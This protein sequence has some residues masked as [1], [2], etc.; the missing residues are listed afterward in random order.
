MSF[1]KPDLG[2][3]FW[4]VGTGDSST[5][6][7]KDK[8]IQIDLHNMSKAVDEDEPY[9]E[10]VE[11]LKNSL[12]K[13]SDKP[14]LDV[15]ILTHADLD[16]VK[17]FGELLKA[18]DIGEIWCTPRVFQESFTDLG[19]EAY[20][21]KKEAER[22]VKLLGD[23]ELKE[24]DRIKVIGYAGILDSGKYDDI[25]TKE[26][27]TIPGEAVTTFNEVDLGGEIEVFVHSPFKY[28]L[29]KEERNETSI[30]FQL[31]LKSG[32]KKGKFLFL[33]DLSYETLK[34]VF[35]TSQGNNEESID[36]NVMLA[37]HHCSK[38]VMFLRS[39][40]K[41]DEFQSDI[42]EMISKAMLDG[43]YIISS[44][45]A[46]RNEDKDGDNPPHIKAKKKY[47]TILDSNDNFL[48]TQEHPN[49]E[50]PEPIVFSVDNNGFTY[51]GKSSKSKR[52]S[53]DSALKKSLGV[54][55]GHT[56]QVGHGFKC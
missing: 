25:L 51:D 44:S 12:P 14:F 35:E 53:V 45:E 36:F 23:K 43:G 4:P 34:K 42:M 22:R 18:V 28:E 3:V 1:T 41:K 16:H 20:Q 37:P 56:S 13:K 10:I 2:V 19:E 21:F 32:D 55:A 6:F 8:T 30:G 29:E 47:L 52:E 17:G 39:D 48:C 27:I 54:S 49:K 46:F 11:E 40:D 24:G 26:V 5:V 31:T 7:I 50:S 15:F 9:V 38:K 33:G